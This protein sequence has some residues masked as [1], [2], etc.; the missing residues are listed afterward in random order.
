MN[1]KKLAALLI[2][3]AAFAG[4][5]SSFDVTAGAEGA[6][7]T[8]GTEISG[9]A[10]R[11]K[12]SVESYDE[13]GFPCVRIVPSAAGNVIRYTL[14]GT[15]PT[16]DS[17]VYEVGKA[18]SVKEPAQIRAAEFDQNGKKLSGAKKALSPRTASVTFEAER[19][20]SGTAVRLS[21]ETVGAKIYYTTDG[22]KPNEG[23]SVYTSELFFSEPA[24]IRAYAVSAALSPGEITDTEVTITEETAE[25]KPAEPAEEEEPVKITTSQKIKYKQT[26]LPNDGSARITL[27]PSK[28]SNVIYYTTDGSAPSPKSKK[29]TDRI[30]FTEPGVLRAL[31]YTKKGELV[32]SLK[33]AATP[34]VMP[35]ELACVDFAVGTRSIRI[36]TN[37]PDATIYYTIDGSKP[38]AEYSNVYTAPVVIS[39]AA[40]IRAF[41]VKENYKDSAYV[42]E[43]GS[44]IPLVLEN[45]RAD[46]PAFAE[47]VSYINQRRQASGLLDLILDPGL[48]Y[49]AN[50]R[51][52][53][54]TIEH[55]HNRLDGK[56]FN[57]IFEECGVFVEYS[58]ESLTQSE[59]AQEFAVEVLSRTEESNALL[60]NNKRLNS[61]GVGYCTRNGK[62]YWVLIAAKMN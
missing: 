41:A 2:S 36:T 18:L 23:S 62:T 57:S 60:T 38:T 49:A 43:Y 47:A 25:E 51:A 42:A 20:E 59:T 14:D 15:A 27:T 28:S 19:R 30:R 50:I 12:I 32:A 46:D 37:T 31:E 33:V 48:T 55:S 17:P 52:K 22:T 45:Y 7:H 53:E 24:K 61:I 26:T 39:N 11:V 56:P 5:L 16:S 58:V 40:Q 35:V 1:F 29:Y 3:A 9:S 34:R 13:H 4:S 8:A 44:S 54:V 21:C 6:W 10:G